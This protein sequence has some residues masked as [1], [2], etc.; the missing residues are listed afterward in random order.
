MKT[1]GRKPSRY[2]SQK[3]GNEYVVSDYGIDIFRG[4]TRKEARSYLGVMR[5]SERFR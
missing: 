5:Y 1:M 3:E 2:S 4:R